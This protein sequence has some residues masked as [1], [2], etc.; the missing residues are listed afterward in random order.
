MSL[1]GWSFRGLGSLNAIP[2]LKYLVRHFNLNI[3]FL[4]EKLVSRNKIEDLRY[5]LSFDFCFS[6][7][8]SG[9]AGGLALFL[10]H[11]L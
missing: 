2:D 9:R 3:L 5:L 8:R 6:I 11:F 7:D 1:I 10:A 4:S